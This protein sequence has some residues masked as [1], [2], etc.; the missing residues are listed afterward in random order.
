MTLRKILLRLLTQLAINDH[1]SVQGLILAFPV[2][3]RDFG[4]DDI[5]AAGINGLRI[6][7]ICGESDWAIEG[8]KEMSVIFDKLDL[9]NRIVIYPDLGHGYP[10]DFSNQ[11]MKSI[12]YIEN[13]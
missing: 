9:P 1:L 3:P 4:A 2:K 6:S 10:D 5:Y 8:Q 13:K 11:I 7:M 12:E